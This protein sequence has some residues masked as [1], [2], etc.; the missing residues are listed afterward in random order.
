MLL[1]LPASVQ[2][3][4][5]P[6]LRLATRAGNMALLCPLGTNRCPTKNSVLFPYN[7]SFIDQACWVN[8]TGHKPRFFACSWIL[9]PSQ[10]ISTEK[11]EHHAWSLTMYTPFVSLRIRLSSALSPFP[12]YFLHVQRRGSEV[13]AKVTC[14]T[15]FCEKQIKAEISKQDSVSSRRLITRYKI[16]GLKKSN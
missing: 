1:D 2:K 13:E 16:T 12:L 9:T 10:S 4:L 3:E 8:M 15:G 14:Q 11:T 5:N 6:E 7:K